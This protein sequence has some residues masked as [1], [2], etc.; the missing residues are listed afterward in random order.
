MTG[1]M[2]WKKWGFALAALSFLI[3]TDVYR[4]SNE[5]SS[6]GYSFVDAVS[7][8]TRPGTSVV[9]LIASDFDQ[10][11]NPAS[12]DGELTEAQVEDMVR[13]AVAMA[14]GLHQ[15]IEADA[16]W[17]V[18]KVNIVELKEQGSGVITDWRVVKGLIKILHEIVPKAR[19]SIAEGAGDWVPPGSPEVQGRMLFADGFEIAGFRQLLSDPDLEGI[20]LDII[21]LNFDDPV[22]VS[23]PDGG[24]SRDKWKL[25]LSVL[26]CD[27]LIT[28][29]VL[30]I[31]D[32]IGMTNAI[33]NF[34]GI[35]PGIIYGWPKLNGY[36]PRSGNPGIPHVPG[37]LDE[38]IVDLFTAAE[39]D[40]AVVDAIMCM[41]RFKTD[42]NDGNPV[43]MNTIIA[44]ADVVAADA[45]SAQLIGLNPLDFE[46]ITL[47]AHKGL[48]QCNLDRIKVKGA[49]I[50]QIARRF[51][52]SPADR[53]REGE[54]GH[55]GQGCRTWLVKGPFERAQEKKGQEFIDVTAPQVLPGQNDWS[56]PVYFHDDRIDLDKYYDDPFDCVVYAYAEFDAMQAQEAELWV[57]SDESMKVWINGEQVYEHEGRRR[58]RL[59]N[60]RLP[61]GIQEGRNTVLVRADQTR[62]RYDFSLNICEPETDPRYDGNR[63][64]RL[65]FTVPYAKPVAGAPTGKLTELDFE[66]P[67]E[68]IPAGATMLEKAQFMR[69][70]DVLMGSFE[71]CLRFLG[72]EVD[73][74]QL[75]GTTGHAFQICVADSMG[76]DG[77]N[78]VDVAAMKDLYQNL[79][80]EIQ[81]ITAA[82]D[83]PAMA[84]RQQEAWE[85]I[86]Q[87]LD[88]GT[89]AISRFGGFFWVIKGYH[90]KK[91][92]Y[93]VSSFMGGSEPADM[94]DLGLE[95]Q[96]EEGEGGLDVL[97]IGQQRQVDPLASAGQVIRSAV[98]GAHCQPE[99]KYHFGLDAYDHWISELEAGHFERGF[100]LGL[101]S[102]VLAAR[103]AHAGPY[104]RQIA[105]RFPEKVAEKLREAGRC[106]DVELESVNQVAAMFP[107]MG[108]GER[109][110]PKDP[111]ARKKAVALI[112]E[113]QT[114]EKKAVSFL[115]EAL[116]DMQ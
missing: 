50:D 6:P 107:L 70:F 60:D 43:R 32:V 89:P 45:I 95:D 41:E 66:I 35:A 53:G 65:Q 79:G 111:E 103:R 90:P 18:I 69:N 82:A 56:Q 12:R 104:L 54:M 47:A 114:W 1:M 27:F 22:E 31:H 83:D 67:G 84:D 29:P 112:R 88:R 74:T 76:F 3:G 106:Y 68:K 61:I 46:Y 9:G 100:G 23:V 38:T 93:Y 28:V 2:Q 20:N 39:V 59:P 75:M 7:A 19:I 101:T 87:S 108:P 49:A 48:G 64:W 99:G 37:I 96:E 11:K 57:G 97:V 52:K 4:S 109:I 102:G 63:V 42:E 17:V 86:S 81:H 72:V 77:P 92:T 71:G 36:P 58:H 115:E 34:V 91:E 16:E 78:M 94:G 40:F 80:Y 110:D 30:K 113:A 105:N 44:S 24:Y 14:G 26:E 13:Y 25:P 55:Y 10:L 73:S 98:E 62:S 8:A 116:T 5:D 21:D 15:R 51:E 33:K 85:A